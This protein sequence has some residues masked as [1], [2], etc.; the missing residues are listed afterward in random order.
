LNFYVDILS[1]AI[2]IGQSFVVQHTLLLGS[3]S[4]DL[5]DYMKCKKAGHWMGEM[6]C[7]IP[8]VFDRVRMTRSDLLY[9]WL[10]TTTVVGTKSPMD[11]MIGVAFEI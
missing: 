7:E 2:R 9:S 11:W 8:S 5:F 10:K 3:D 1:K 6:A 4:E